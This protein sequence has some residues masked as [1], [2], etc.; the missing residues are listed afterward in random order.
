LTLDVQ[1]FLFRTGPVVAKVYITGFGTTVD[2]ALPIAQAAAGRID[3]WLGQQPAGSAAAPVS[4]E[5]A[6][7]S[8]TVGSV[9]GD[10]ADVSTAGTETTYVDADG[11][12][13]GTITLSDVADPFTEHHP[14]YP[15]DP[16]TRYIM[17]T[18][19]FAASSDQTFEADSYDLLVRDT[20]GYLWG[21][22]SVT[23]PAET[24]IPELTA[25]SLAPGDRT[26]G[27]VGFV[28]PADA[29]IDELLYQPESG[30]LIV[31]ADLVTDPEPAVGTDVPFADDELVGRGTVTVVEVVDPF[32]EHDPS[33]P[34]DAGTRYVMLDV[35]FATTD[36]AFEADPFDILLVDTNGYLWSRGSVTRPPDAAV[37]ELDAQHLAPDNRI[38]GFVPFVVPADAVIDRV[39]YQPDGGRLITLASL[40]G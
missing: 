28:V 33:Y 39:L 19:A 32:T 17:I 16:G 10:T 36:Q 20:D 38:S 1:N 37:P 11:I 34:P 4:S 22:G 21:R 9:P 5:T 35:A 7:T 6:A 27:V 23:L 14:D 12:T 30:R 40:G 8:V 13:R 25:Q 24:P 31:L 15:P 3:E 29:V 2:D 18:I 26:S